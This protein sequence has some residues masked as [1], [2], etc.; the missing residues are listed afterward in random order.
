MVEKG[1]SRPF[2]ERGRCKPSPLAGI[3]YQSP[4]MEDINACR[5]LV[6][7]PHDVANRPDCL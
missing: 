6:S 3:F 5:T 4:M 7:R 2:D 1:F